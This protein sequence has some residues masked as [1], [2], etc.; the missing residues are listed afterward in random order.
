MHAQRRNPAKKGFGAWEA[1][2]KYFITFVKDK[3][4]GLV[5]ELTEFHSESVNPRE[6]CVSLR[7][8]AYLGTEKAFG[9]CPYLRHY[10]IRCQ[11][12]MEKPFHPLQDLPPRSS[13]RP[14]N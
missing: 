8:Y 11:Y 14:S 5:V 6:L 13:W 4:V 1:L 2:T 9:A 3:L 12:T 7:M 10:L